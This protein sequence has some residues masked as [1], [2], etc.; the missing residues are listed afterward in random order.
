MTKPTNQAPEEFRLGNCPRQLDFAFKC[1]EK[2]GALKLTD[3]ANVRHCTVCRESVT[4][5]MTQEE[6]AAALEQNPNA[7]VAH[8]RSALRHVVVE[9]GQLMRR[10]GQGVRTSGKHRSF[11]ERS[12]D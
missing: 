12:D 7:C 8:P 10:P 5:C 2:W 6:I 11:I 1:P 3:D 9:M 4:L